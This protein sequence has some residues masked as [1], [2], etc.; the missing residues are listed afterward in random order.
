MVNSTL[1]RKELREGLWKHALAL[2]LHDPLV[3]D[4]SID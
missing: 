2:A 4:W 1:F 3:S